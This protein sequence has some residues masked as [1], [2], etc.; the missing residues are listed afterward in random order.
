MTATAT[1]LPTITPADLGLVLRIARTIENAYDDYPGVEKRILASILV[2]LEEL[3]PEFDGKKMVQW[4]TE[5]RNEWL[6]QS[7]AQS[8]GLSRS[9]WQAVR[10]LEKLAEQAA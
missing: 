5:S 1:S 2:S 4:L 10:I 9:Q 3:L 8:L 6:H 7:P